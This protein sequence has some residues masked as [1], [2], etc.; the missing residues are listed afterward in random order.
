MTFEAASTYLL[1]TINET[2]SRRSPT[3]LDRMRMFLRE[4]GDPQDAYRTFHVGGTSGKGSTATMIATALTA[5]G[6]RTGLHTKPHLTSMVERARIDGVPIDEDTFGELLEEMMP[7]IA[8]TAGEHGRPSYY[9]TLLALTFLYFARQRVDAAVIEVGVGG[10]LDGTNVITPVVSV[11]T[12]VGLDH[13]EI[14]GDTVEEIA[15]DKSGIAKPGVP[16]AS[17]AAHP[18]RDIIEAACAAVGAPF[19]AVSERATVHA[20]RG[21][22]YG[23]SFEVRTPVA[24][25]ALELPVLGAFQQRNAATAITAL[26]L[27]PPDLLPSPAAV[28]NG[29][30]RLTIPGRMEFFPGHPSVVFDIAHN[31]DK[32]RSL[33]AAL[34][35]EFG[36]RRFSFVIAIG[37]S[38]DATG[39]L[40]PFLALPAGFIFTT[41][42]AAGRTAIRPQ[43]LASIAQERGA[44]ARAIADPVEALSVARRS[45]DGSSIVVVT[46]STFVVA[47]L[48]EWWLSNAGAVSSR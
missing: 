39:V 2:V 27:G 11:I 3:R 14:L 25:Y 43:R 28:E 18:A 1:G 12:N 42:D 34:R 10:T 4:L 31:P 20:E 32:A 6:K 44:F 45:A 13:T 46:G 48:R 21:A 19:V 23:Q 33:A 36:D 24:R 8:R 35:S 9:E 41:F 16:L 22:R 38:K 5:S 26:E 30:A 29:L 40:E 37:E 47:T 15:R 17:D 7:A